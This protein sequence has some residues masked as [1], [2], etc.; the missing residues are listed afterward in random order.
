[1]SEGQWNSVD[2]VVFVGCL[3]IPED[4]LQRDRIHTEQVLPPERMAYMYRGGSVGKVNGLLPTCR[5]LDKMFRKSIDCKGGDKGTIVDYSKNLL[6]RMALDAGPFSI[7][8]F[9]WCEIQSVGE[10]PV[11]GYALVHSLCI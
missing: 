5:Y 10:R 6:H 11:K 3:D 2:Y 4:E 8:D 9:I 1:M 7:F